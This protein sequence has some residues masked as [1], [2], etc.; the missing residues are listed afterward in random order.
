MP[1]VASRMTPPDPPPL[2]APPFSCSPCAALYHEF[3]MAQ[4]WGQRLASASLLYQAA[5][6]W[7]QRQLGLFARHRSQR[8]HQWLPHV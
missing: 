7:R 8:D 6:Q 5:V 3:L 1:T 2:P 4:R